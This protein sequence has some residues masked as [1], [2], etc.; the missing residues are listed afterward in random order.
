M[1]LTILKDRWMGK[2]STEEEVRDRRASMSWLTILRLYI[3]V[4]PRD[5]DGRRR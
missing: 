5:Y 1:S 4:D 3:L 2:S